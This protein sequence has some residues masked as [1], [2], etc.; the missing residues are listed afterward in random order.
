MIHPMRIR[1]KFTVVFGIVFLSVLLIVTASVFA[2]SELLRFQTMADRGTE[3]IARSRTVF[4]LMKDLSVTAFAPELYSRMKDVFYYEKFDVTL[5]E[6]SG[7]VED[8]RQTFRAFMDDGTVRQMARQNSLV[9]DEYATALTMSGKAFGRLDTVMDGFRKLSRTG[10][11]TQGDAYQRIVSSPDQQVSGLFSEVRVTSYYLKNNFESFMNYFVTAM[12]ARVEATRLAL[13]WF[14]LGTAL[15][16]VAISLTFSMMVGNRIVR[17][18]GALRAAMA[19]VSRGDFSH[20]LSIRS[21]DELGELA[22]G[23]NRLARDLKNNVDRLLVVSRDIGARIDPTTD[24]AALR[25]TIVDTSTRDIRAAGMVLLPAP[26]AVGG[27]APPVA[28]GLLAGERERLSLRAVVG[29]A[30]AGPLFLVPEAEDLPF[31]S[32]LACP[33]RGP[34]GSHG[35]LAAVT[36]SGAPEFTDLD[37]VLFQSLADFAALGIENYLKYREL[38]ELREAEYQSLQAR[39]QP[40]FLY[41]VLN[42][43]VGLN[44]MGDRTGLEAAVLDLK[45]LLRYT[46]APEGTVT[47]AEELAFVTKYLEL[48]KLRFG[49]RF[50]FRIDCDPRCQSLALPKLLLQPLAENALIHGIELLARPGLLTIAARPAPGGVAVWVEDNGA[51]FDLA[52]HDPSRR[53]GLSNVTK[54]L[55]LAYPGSDFHIVSAPGQGCRVDLLILTPGTPV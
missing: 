1:D 8:F 5:R 24:L 32:V 11:L 3:L 28:S 51:G 27:T 16:S 50:D 25:R 29:P 18:V 17:H 30:L 31:S 19:G 42:G 47:L 43:V 44:R 21:R 22:E 6:W 49:E 33:L 14:F 13:T 52:A 46:L 20:R 10:L 4:N 2:M 48:Q 45:D 15:A 26:G 23:I 37:F 40:H 7:A 9:G 54:R 41:N 39:I 34:S 53:V 55:E 38:I 36:A 35:V 12:T